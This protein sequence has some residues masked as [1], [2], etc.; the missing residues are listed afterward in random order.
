MAP[1]SPL[2]MELPSG[3]HHSCSKWCLFILLLMAPPAAAKN[4]NMLAVKG[5]FCSFC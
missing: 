3:Q 2:I 1:L 5:V 4:S